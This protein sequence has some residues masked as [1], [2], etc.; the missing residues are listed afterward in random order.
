MVSL[1]A[2]KRLT[3]NFWLYEFLRS[4]DH[5]GLAGELDPKLYHIGNLHMLCA[6]IL[7]PTRKHLRCP[8]VITSGFR[9]PELN[10]AVGG[11][12]RSLHMHGKAA[13]ITIANPD[14]LF[15]AYEF[16]RDELPYAYS[17]VSYYRERNF[18]HVGLPHP[19][20]CQNEEIVR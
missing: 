4:K 2:K 20:R 5:P 13:D 14:H 18:I 1:Q 7:E 8:V 11:S 16:I 15:K 17:L 6:T 10:E 19:G 12:D 3:N 9:S